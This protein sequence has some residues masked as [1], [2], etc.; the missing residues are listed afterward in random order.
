MWINNESQQTVAI[1]VTIE[2]LTKKKSF[3]RWNPKEIKWFE[4]SQNA[5]W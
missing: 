2:F 5:N 3:Y 1:Y 4:Q